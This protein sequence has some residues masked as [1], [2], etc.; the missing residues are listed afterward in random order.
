MHFL[1]A[2]LLWVISL[3]AAYGVGKS[4]VESKH[5]GGWPRLVAWALASLAAI[6]FTSAYLLLVVAALETFSG[7][8][9]VREQVEPLWTSWYSWVIA[10]LAGF[11]GP[12]FFF[13][14][15]RHYRGGVN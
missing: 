12:F 4:W 10:P 7:D 3:G 2:A 11:L 5:A 9:L 6:G 13:P 15:G 14:L 1:F 8:L